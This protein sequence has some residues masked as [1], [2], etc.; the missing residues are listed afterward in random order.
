M[1]YLCNAKLIAI[2]IEC[3]NKKTYLLFLFLLECLVSYSQQYNQ[4]SQLIEALKL[5]VNVVDLSLS[6]DIK[7]DEPRLSY[8]NLTGLTSMPTSKSS[9]INC[10]ME[11]YDGAGHYFKKRVSIHAQGG[12]SLSL[13]KKNFACEFYED[14]WKESTTDIRF[15]DWVKQ[16]A[17]HFKAFYT[18]FSRGL[19]EMGYKMFARVVEDRKPYWER[20]GYVKDSRARCFPDGFPCIVYL[21]GRFYG[22]F[23]WQLKKHRK[24]MN[25]EKHEACHI[26]LDGKTNDDNL[27]HG[28][29]RWGQFEVRNP[30]DLY[31]KSGAVYDGDSPKELLG[32][33]DSNMTDD[34]KDV[35][36]AKKRSIQVKEAILRL[37]NYHAEL[38]MIEKSGVE[39]LKARFEECFE[40]ESLLDYVVFYYFQA[41][42][43]GSLKNWQWFTYDGYKWLVT[44]YDL[45]Q[46]LGLGLYGQVRPANFPIEYL[47]S[48]PFYWLDKYYR[49]EIKQRWHQLRNG[50]IISG[51]T[52]VPIAIDWCERVGDSFYDLERQKWP[53][54]PCYCEAICR[55]GWKTS[56]RWD[57]YDRTAEYNDGTTY[58]P[59]DLAKLEGRLWEATDIVKRINPIVRNACPDSLARLVAWIPERISFLD[60]YFNYDGKNTN[61][62]PNPNV[63]DHNPIAIYTLSGQRVEHPGHGIYIYHYKKGKSRK[64]ILR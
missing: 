29:V 47:T 61:I 4:F 43:D 25:M 33:I 48:G 16:D 20:G 52:F 2:M 58:Y 24:N 30:K 35:V 40:L 6:A 54:S 39:A 42:G 19:G 55:R 9:I 36:E 3:L 28:H 22:I 56:E 23:A 37:S 51:E 21:N 27:F 50:G 26:H 49:N 18:D 17:F 10:W 12:Y 1:L 41:N 60:Q 59:G 62:I 13:P 8:V 44:P 5:D 57:L 45:D 14:E 64:V 32:E 7:L 11:F 38:E 63:T 31:T 34:K 15:G 53:E 46:T